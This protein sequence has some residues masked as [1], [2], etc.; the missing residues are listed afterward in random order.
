MTCSY[1]AYF[2]LV[3]GSVALA[4]P[5]GIGI[6]VSS[7]VWL[8]RRTDGDASPLPGLRLLGLGLLLL[9]WT[10]LMRRHAPRLMVRAG[11]W[12]SWGCGDAYPRNERELV[13]AVSD[14][15]KK[16]RRNPE[17]VGAAWGHFITRRGAVG[18]RIYTHRMLGRDQTPGTG[19]EF[20]YCGNTIR[21]MVEHYKKNGGQTFSTHPTMD[22]ISI[23]AWFAMGNHGNGG[24]HRETKGSSDT[25][26]LAR[27][28]NMATGKVQEMPYSELR[29]AFDTSHRSYCVVSVA[30]QN[31]VENKV[32]QKQGIVVDSYL[33]ATQWLAEGAYLRV[34]FQGAGRDYAVG[35]RWQ[36]KY[37]EKEWDS[38][39]DPHKCGCSRVC[40]YAQVDTCSVWGGWHE[41]MVKFRGRSSY[42]N[43]NRWMPLLF[44][45]ET[46]FVVAVGYYNFEIIFKLEGGALNGLVLYELTR[47]LIRM[48]N[49]HGGRSEI[50]Y[51]KSSSETPIFLDVVLRRSADFSAP[52]RM[53][54][55]DFGVSEAA[56]HPGKYWP[57]STAPCK[58]VS[59]HDMYYPTAVTA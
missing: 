50:R 27:V 54:A 51:G 13:E 25:L 26:K 20:W 31:L 23:G 7:I 47:S 56:L 39:L 15:K 45:I 41:S 37:D 38:H 30:F 12:P 14:I 43:A 48:H 1:N 9:L 10:A 33:S 28:L 16:Y 53:L 24:N 55:H 59:L 18:P 40:L 11:A 46:V 8:G 22:Y 44:P 4:L 17:I 57:A 58:R 5:T 36:D 3:W 19:G 52:F 2:L 6:V 29:K 21:S 32:V 49:T 35:V 42:V 34:M